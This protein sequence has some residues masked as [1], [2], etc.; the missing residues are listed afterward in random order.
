MDGRQFVSGPNGMATITINKVGVYRLDALIDQYHDLS[1]RI[2]FG[3]WAEESYLPSKDVKVPTDG[4]I[5]VG[6]NVY[7][8]VSMNFVGLDKI[9]V[10]R[11]RITAIMIRSAQGDIFNLTPYQ[12]PWLPSSRTDRRATGLEQTDL[13]YSII[14]VTIDGSNVVNSAQQRFVAKPDDEWN[15]SL[16]LYSLYINT[17]DGLFG[18]PI[19]K[20]VNIQSPD[21]QTK[22]YPLDKS[23]TLLLHSL[24]RG[25]YHIELLGATGMGTSVPVALSRNQ[26]VNVNV[27]TRPDMV[28]AG[29]AGLSLAIGIIIFGRPWLIQ[30]LMKKRRALSRKTDWSSFNEN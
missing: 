13:L 21:G 1:Q 5:Q 23:G 14:N 18:S 26:V 4:V 16:L 3:R 19:G 9:P 24:A 7:H 11:Q 22:N 17:K 12:A 25:I 27:I 28:V 30:S 29:V 2:E 20:S 10:D 15:I 6:L 8:Q